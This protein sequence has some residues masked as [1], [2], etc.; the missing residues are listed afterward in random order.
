MI[1]DVMLKGLEKR[2]IKIKDID[3]GIFEEAYFI[4]RGGKMDVP[5][6]DMISEASR[7][8]E[9]NSLDR[10]MGG[11]LPR[12]RARTLILLIAG[13]VAAIATVIGLLIFI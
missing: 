9:E 10:R 6:P 3:S 2:V 11:S 5:A 13:G 1:G 7:I 4:L 12:T 8:I